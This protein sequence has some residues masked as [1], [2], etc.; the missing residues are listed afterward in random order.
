[1]V[2]VTALLSVDSDNQNHRY[3]DIVLSHLSQENNQS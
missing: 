2:E 3:F 1:M